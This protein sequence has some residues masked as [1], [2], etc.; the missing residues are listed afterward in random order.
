MDP[1]PKNRGSSIARFVFVAWLAAADP[2]RAEDADIEKWVGSAT[3]ALARRDYAKAIADAK[4]AQ[5]LERAEHRSLLVLGKAY[6]ALGDFKAADAAFEFDLIQ[7]CPEAEEKAVAQLE[8]Q[9]L[10]GRIGLLEKEIAAAPDA[11][12]EESRWKTIAGLTERVGAREAIDLYTR[13]IA[14]YGPNWPLRARADVRH[15]HTDDHPQARADYQ[16]YLLEAKQPVD[17]EKPLSFLDGEIGDDEMIRICTA[18]IGRAPNETAAYEERGK[19]HRKKGAMA[20][21]V[22]DLRRAYQMRP[23]DQG[24]RNQLVWMQGHKPLHR[25]R[26]PDLAGPHLEAARKLAKEGKHEKAINECHDAR[27]AD[28]ECYDAHLL[29]GDCRMALKQYEKAMEAYTAAENLRAHQDASW[30]IVQITDARDALRKER[31]ARLKDVPAD[32]TDPAL[33]RTR[34]LLLL[35]DKDSKPAH[36]EFRRLAALLPKDPDPLLSIGDDLLNGDQRKQHFAE[37]EAVYRQAL[38]RRP[39]DVRILRRL[40]D[41][42]SDQDREDAV[43][44]D[45]T[46]R[47]GQDDR[48]A[49]GYFARARAKA[50][51]KQWA[52]AIEDALKTLEIDPTFDEARRLLLEIHTRA[53]N[54]DGVEATARAGLAYDPNDVTWA[55]ALGDAAW[56]KKD[57]SGAKGHYQHAVG[58]DPYNGETYGNFAELAVKA[59]WIP[60]AIENYQKQCDCY[61]RDFEMAVRFGQ[62]LA[63]QGEYKKATLQ[64]ERAAAATSDDVSRENA[65]EE[66]GHWHYVVGNHP[67]AVGAY[68]RLLAI[69]DNDYIR[70]QRSLVLV[71][72]G[73]ARQV[74]DE[75]SAGIV[76]YPD[77]AFLFVARANAY[78]SMEQTDKSAA[79]YT[80]AL[81]LKGECA[82]ALRGFAIL[83]AGENRHSETIEL[84]DRYLKIDGD[85]TGILHLR[86]FACLKR[87]FSSPKR[88]DLEQAL[89]GWKKCRELDPKSAAFK[90]NCEVTEG[91]MQEEKRQ[92][93]AEMARITAAAEQAARLER[94]AEQRRRKLAEQRFLE[95]TEPQLHRKREPKPD[96]VDQLVEA[97]HNLRA[98]DNSGFQRMVDQN[99]KAGAELQR[100]MNEDAQMNRRLDEIGR[101]FGK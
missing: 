97:L 86:S 38:E 3:A 27:N 82:E 50:G 96:F 10:L 77:S 25:G 80:A 94:E 32:S 85:D 68:D 53:K 78:R 65:L 79:D 92:A 73:K 16:R 21:A 13:L 71:E 46:R 43:I 60:L 31:A 72:A 66:L 4:Q 76:R 101:K 90:R 30:A 58:L 61:P 41:L 88:G 93:S 63:H 12:A 52:D 36:A 74:V 24:L 28:P 35:E 100:N 48:F 8:R 37:A 59:G 20:R 49:D 83:R 34:A 69:R 17:V 39:D 18:V 14:E 62:F 70:W 29:L 64:F 15:Y 98:P 42:Q 45:C 57:A 51:L 7:K 40:W 91:V 1:I 99:W 22:A 5:E 54:W 89:A 19:A 2:A 87:H 81:G 44:A 67:E 9:A 23:N 95:A 75:T 55:W 56:E 26:R 84:C 33:V 47:I 11:K 6:L